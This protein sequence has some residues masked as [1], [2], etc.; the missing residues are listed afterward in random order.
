MLRQWRKNNLKHNFMFGFTKKEVAENQ[1]RRKTFGSGFFGWRDTRDSF[2]LDVI[3]PE[4]DFWTEWSLRHGIDRYFESNRVENS[5]PDF[6]YRDIFKLFYTEKEDFKVEA[7]TDMQW[8]HKLLCK[9]DNYMLKIITENSYLNSFI[10]TKNIIKAIN[11]NEWKKSACKG[12]G[13]PNEKDIQQQM[14]ESVDNGDTKSFEQAVKQ[15]LQEAEKEMKETKNLMDTLGISG[16]GKGESD[17]K[18]YETLAGIKQHLGNVS[19]N[20]KDIERFV[21]KSIKGFKTSLYGKGNMV[22]E[23]ILETDEIL[24]MDDYHL[25][26]FPEL[27]EDVAVFR[28]NP[29]MMFDVYVDKSGSM[30]SNVNCGT[31]GIECLNLVKILAY[32]MEK[33]GLLNNMFTFDTKLSS[34]NKEKIFNIATGGGTIIDIAI[35]NAQ[36]TGIPSVVIT[37]GD[38]R[39]HEKC[40]HVYLMN[41]S[42]TLNYTKELEFYTENKRC[43]LF[44]NNKFS[45]VIA[46]DGRITYES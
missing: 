22:Q 24:D 1:S 2:R 37:D 34:V 19:L 11:D 4:L 13:N 9:V 29:T 40:N 14:K 44:Q 21:K 33:M 32:K 6:M 36:K 46:K 5:T 8:W 26:N 3:K 16:A 15:G 30:N 23:S 25:L 18:L 41:I 28:D 42:Q 20:R 39:I 7:E 31:S 10:I 43:I 35:K 12:K 38:D 45:N 27:I 17:E